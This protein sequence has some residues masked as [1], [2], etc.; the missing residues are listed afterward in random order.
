MLPLLQKVAERLKLYLDCRFRKRKARTSDKI[1]WKDEDDNEVDYD[2]VMELD[3]T[4][5]TRGIPVAFFECFWR[6]GA[7][8]SKD[9]AR[10]DSGKLM[11]MRDVHPTAAADRSGPTGTPSR[12]AS[13]RGGAEEVRDAPGPPRGVAGDLDDS[14]FSGK[15]WGMIRTEL[16]RHGGRLAHT[17]VIYDGSRQRDPEVTALYRYYDHFAP[18]PQA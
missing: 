16:E 11:P 17:Y 10:D 1:I 13:W 8:H 7:R 4:D 5:E 18:K 15:T 6:R 14:Y 12:T 9:K 3:G 2:F